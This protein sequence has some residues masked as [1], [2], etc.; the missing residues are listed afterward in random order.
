MGTSGAAGSAKGAVAKKASCAFL[1]LFWIE[2]MF[3]VS[4]HW[5]GR[6]ILL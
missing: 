4:Y 5:S 3:D 1:K 2:F 6:L